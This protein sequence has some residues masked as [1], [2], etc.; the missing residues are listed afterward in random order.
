MLIKEIIATAETFAPLSYSFSAIEKGYY[1]NSG[2]LIGSDENETQNVL[3]ALD[4]NKS[5][6]K[7]AQELGARLIFTH[8]PAIYKPIKCVSGVLADCL[9]SGISVYSAHL[10]LDVARGGIEDGLC[11]LLGGKNAEIKEIITE[12]VG[13]GRTFCVEPK[14]L[15]QFVCEFTEKIGVKKYMLF[16]DEKRVINKV[17]SFCGAGL[18]EFAALE[19]NDVDLLVSADISHH[20]LLA[21]LENDKCVL[22]LTHYSSEAFAFKAF[23]EKL[24]EKLKIKLHF[25]LDE[26]FL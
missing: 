13:F 20:V 6:L 1:D 17:S 25:Y 12:N 19:K 18:D 7:T 4:L 8:H 9:S 2:L 21:A 15:K 3:F 14:T 5:V 16:G 23:A 22:Q 24:C 11:K 26:R 10:N